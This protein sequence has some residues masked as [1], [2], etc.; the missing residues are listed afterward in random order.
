MLPSSLNPTITISI[1]A[2]FDWRLPPFI[3]P[4]LQKTNIGD[5]PR[6]RI[7]SYHSPNQGHCFKRNASTFVWTSTKT[8]TF[9]TRGLMNVRHFRTHLFTVFV[10][11]TN[12][13]CMYK[14]YWLKY[15]E[16]TH[17]VCT[18]H[19]LYYPFFYLFKFI[20]LGVKIFW[21]FEAHNVKGEEEQTWW[22]VDPKHQIVEHI[23]H[24]AF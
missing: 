11:S 7:V 23:Q 18:F 8:T 4:L 21:R 16:S 14:K 1:V 13:V 5:E 20:F 2:K 15:Q 10:I 22:L 6:G 24:D 3:R 19:G 17:S 9:K 12:F